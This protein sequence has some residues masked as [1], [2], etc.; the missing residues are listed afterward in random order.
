MRIVSYLLLVAG[1]VIVVF[2][3]LVAGFELYGSFAATEV[4]EFAVGSE[5]DRSDTEATTQEKHRLS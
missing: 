4:A 1:V 5:L 2:V 3:E